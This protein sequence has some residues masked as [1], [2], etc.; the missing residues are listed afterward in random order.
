[1]AAHFQIDILR[2]N[3]DSA[4]RKT[5]QNNIAPARVVKILE[6]AR[7]EFYSAVPVQ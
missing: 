1:M 3:G 5:M 2:V 4:F 7:T 6:H